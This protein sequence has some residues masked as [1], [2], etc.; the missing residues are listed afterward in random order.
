MQVSQSPEVKQSMKLVQDQLVERCPEL[1]DTIIDVES[2]HLTLMVMNLEE[3]GALVPLSAE[4]LDS[5]VS[6]L[7]ENGLLKPIDVKLKGLG[8]FKKKVNMLLKL[9]RVPSFV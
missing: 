9:N 6:I 8:T 5:A 4:L 2:A 7:R 1:E 3:A